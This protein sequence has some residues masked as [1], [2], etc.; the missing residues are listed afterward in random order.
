MQRLT[1][2][3][4]AILMAGAS[5]SLSQSHAA[6]AAPMVQSPRPIP[7]RI[8]EVPTKIFSTIA[9]AFSPDGARLALLGF[10]DAMRQRLC[11]EVLDTRSW[12]SVA[13]LD[14]PNGRP[15]LFSGALAFS[16][17]G[18]LLAAGQLV[19]RTWRTSDWQPAFDIPGPF[20]RGT[21]AANAVLG[22]TF[23][24]DG[25]SI[26]ALYRDVWYPQ[27]VSGGARRE[28]ADLDIARLAALQSG[29]TPSYFPVNM[30]GFYD[31]VTGRQ[32]AEA[33]PTGRNP[34]ARPMLSSAVAQAGRGSDVY[35][36]W[37]QVGPSDG[38]PPPKLTF[39][40]G[41]VGPGAAE[42]PV[43]L[44]FLEVATALATSSDGAT[45]VAGSSTGNRSSQFGP[46][47]GSSTLPRDNSP[48]LIHGAS[49]ATQTTMPPAG[50]VA[51]L[52]LTP[53]G[54]LISCSKIA[55]EEGP[56]QVW[57]PKTGELVASYAF[58]GLKPSQYLVCAIDADH[59]SIA[60]PQ[61]RGTSSPDQLLI[62]HVP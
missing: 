23:T 34:A 55:G 47:D 41:R 29:R 38:P 24:G 53:R 9:L 59:R 21:W 60:I 46:A 54:D 40:A 28:I 42:A 10:C 43:S 14:A 6:D 49:G 31:T 15:G 57:A 62:S 35:V 48:I 61:A 22:M 25:K 33:Y 45:F 30:V 8:N 32:I 37:A 58:N 50:G 51:A 5:F 44:A 27:T 18:R 7:A 3:I 26:A 4:A 56:V 20:A 13:F 19:L 1:G 17:D 16:P 36:A 52:A 11:V 2:F 12:R 39:Y